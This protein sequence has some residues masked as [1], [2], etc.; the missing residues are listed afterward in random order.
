MDINIQDTQNL[1]FQVAL[2]GA[3]QEAWACKVVCVC[4]WRGCGL[5]SPLAGI[6]GLMTLLGAV[7]LQD[8]LT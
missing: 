5:L 8:T 6:L 7:Q 3:Q 1:H 2:W 4:V